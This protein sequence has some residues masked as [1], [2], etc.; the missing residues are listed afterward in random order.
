MGAVWRTLRITVLLLVLLVVAAQAWFDRFS[1]T[2][3][4]R[5]IFVGAFPVSADASPVTTD[6]LAKL[7]QGK[8]DEVTAF[9]NAE[10]RRYGVGI[11]EPIELQLYPTLAH[12]PPALDSDAGVFTRILWGL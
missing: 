11:D 9:L 1:T 10:A 2:R 12:A 7:D 5:T 3:W 4:Q 6:Y 8:I